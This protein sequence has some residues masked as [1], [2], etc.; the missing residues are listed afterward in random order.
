MMP[1]ERMRKTG[2]RE[3]TVA[4]QIAL[5]GLQ[6]SR[7]LKQRAKNTA[8]MGV[9]AALEKGLGGRE[10]GFRATRHLEPQ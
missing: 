2:I 1:E 5:A 9:Q 6:S 10:L 3:G 8:A 4:Q 7:I